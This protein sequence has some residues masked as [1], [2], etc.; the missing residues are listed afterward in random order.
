MIRQALFISV[1][2][3]A[4]CG[5]SQKENSGTA[6]QTNDAANSEASTKIV[7]IPK[8][9]GNPYFDQV[10]KGFET[11]AKEWKLDYATQAPATADATSQLPII[12]DQV[13][14]GVQVLVLSAN[15]P[16]ALN[17]EL[18][19]AKQNGVTII[20]VDSDLTGN[21]SHRDVGILPTDFSKIGPSQLELLGSLMNYDGEFA[22]LSAT[23]DA[24]NQNAWIEGLKDALKDSKYAKMKLVEI[25][26]GDDEPQKSSTECESLLTK[27]P[28]LRGILSPTSVGL[29]AAA[30]VLENAGVYPGGAKANGPGVVLTGL[31]TP[32]QMK[33]AVEKGVVQ[34]FQ[35]WDPADMGE[36]AAFIGKQLHRKALTLSVGSEIEVPN[37]GSIIV[38]ENKVLFAGPLMTFDKANI[39]NYDF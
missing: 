28:N 27:H 25:V 1:V 10:S 5:C 26:Y 36:I 18:D 38:G 3:L 21:E 19:R 11:A 16:D 23:V 22:I 32:N 4:V 9:T 8:N 12:R 35:L 15:S 20:T 6:T 14:Q 37:H 30:Q 17:E 34:K 33:K 31:S 13:Q 7:F 39:A 29:A 2:L 24:P